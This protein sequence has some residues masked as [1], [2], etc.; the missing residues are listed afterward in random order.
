MVRQDAH[1]E[2]HV[3]LVLVDSPGVGDSLIVLD[4]TDGLTCARG[5]ESQMNKRKGRRKI[6]TQVL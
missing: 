5:G 1:R 2:K 3:L 6:A 4:H